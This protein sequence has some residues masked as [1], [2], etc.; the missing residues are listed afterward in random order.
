M[1]LNIP[2]ERIAITYNL[3]KM[4]LFNFAKSTLSDNK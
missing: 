4:K 2:N 3:I 1:W